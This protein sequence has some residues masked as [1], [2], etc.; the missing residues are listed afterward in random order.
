M[1]EKLM[2]L[3]DL[4]GGEF[5]GPASP[6]RGDTLFGGHLIAQCLAAGQLTVADDRHVNSLHAYFTR[7]GDVDLPVTITV[8]AVRDGRSFSWRE[9]AAS[10]GGKE[11]FRMSA[12]YQVPAESPDYA[13]PARPDV[14][15]PEEV[16]LTYGE[17]TMRQTGE[18]TWD[19]MERPIDIRYVNAPE[20]SRGTAVTES[21]LMWMRIPERL[22]DTPAIHHAGLAYL[23][24]ATLVDHVM[25]PHGMRW[26]DGDFLGT[27]LDHAMW[28]HRFAR[29]DEW[30]L[31]EQTVEST[32]G[33]RGLARGYFFDR[34]GALIATCMQEGLMRWVRY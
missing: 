31:F 34:D 15:P 7:P 26:Q 30:L 9:T 11:L 29:A 24:D 19:G 21:Q 32:G 28:F 16:P 3:A 14:P 18:D 20:T 1:F 10:Q 2:T 8:H 13:R 5:E 22:P 4:D 27:S 23:S 17:F 25:L 6:E 12:S 33:G